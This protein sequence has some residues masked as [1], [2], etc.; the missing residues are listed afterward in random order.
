MLLIYTVSAAERYLSA[1]CCVS[2]QESYYSDAMITCQFVFL[3][4]EHAQS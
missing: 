3:V 2:A 1:I 4:R